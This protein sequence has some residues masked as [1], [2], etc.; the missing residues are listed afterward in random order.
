MT[1]GENFMRVIKG[2]TPA[3]APRFSFFGAPDPYSKKPIPCV[4]VGYNLWGFKPNENGGFT[5]MFGVP[6][7]PTKETGGMFL[8]TPNVFILKDVR[9]WREVIKLPSLEGI[10]WE[11]EARKTLDQVDGML[12]GQGLTRNDVATILGTHVGYFQMLCN[13]M[14]FSEG[15]V[16]LIEEPEAVHELYSYLADF[17][18]EIT[19]QALTYFKPDILGI[20]DD[21][22]TMS[23]PFM[24]LQVFRDVIKP[25]H[26]RL[27]R[28]AQDRGLPVMMHNCGRCEDFIDDWREYGVNSWNPAQVSNDLDG[29]KKKYGN[30]MVLIGCWDSQGP[31]GWPGASEEL[32]RQAVRDCIDRYAAGG[33]FMFLASTYGPAGDEEL[34]NRRR[35]ISSEYEAYREHPYR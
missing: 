16:A 2:E 5:D 23:N 15:L 35:W 4:S 6:Y 30:G 1:E 3:W 7:T 10:D 20:T 25:Y 11:G 19:R 17:Y 22:A 27:G 24:S 18:D 34:E 31:A 14:G 33:G 21:T 9:R 29:I 13:F 12:K 32:V 28:L 26:V 8:P